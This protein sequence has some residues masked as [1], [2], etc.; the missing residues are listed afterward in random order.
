M[1][2]RQKQNAELD[3]FTLLIIS[4]PF[5]SSKIGHSVHDC[6]ANH[7][8]HRSLINKSTHTHHL[9]VVARG[10]TSGVKNLI[11]FSNTGTSFR[12]VYCSKS[13]LRKWMKKQKSASQPLSSKKRI[14]SSLCNV[15]SLQTL[16]N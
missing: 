11:C 8:D 15:I 10:L 16:A 6:L 13:L 14:A 1:H 2:A 4:S 3:V 5:I 9:A 7:H 12:A